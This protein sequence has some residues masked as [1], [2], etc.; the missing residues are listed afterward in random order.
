MTDF[1]ELV[2]AR[3]QVTIRTEIYTSLADEGVTIQGL[4]PTSL[5]KALPE[6]F[7]Q[8]EADAEQSR[9]DMT[10]AAFPSGAVQLTTRPGWMHLHATDF[11]QI[12]P[13]PALETLGQMRITATSAAASSTI[14][15]GQLVIRYG[16]GASQRLYTN[17][18]G[19][20]PIPGSYV[21]VAMTAQVAG[22]A[23]N[24]GNNATLYLV[25]AYPGL[26]ATNPP[27][28]GTQTWITRRGR[29]AEALVSIKQRCDERWAD[30]SFEV[31]S[32]RFARIIRDAFEASGETNPIVRIY[33][34]DTNPDG[35]GSVWVYMARDGT[36]ATADDVT[37]VDAYVTPR[38]R[39][40]GGP[41]KSYAAST[42]T[43][44]LDGT[45]KGPSN[46]ATAL[47]QAS[48]AL[49]ALAPTYAIGGDKVYREQVESALFTGVTGAKNVILTIDE[50][51]DIPAGSIVEF[52]IGTITVTP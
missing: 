26:S 32:Q 29:D 46:S 35:P 51:T 37:L 4:Q 2:I 36:T 23:G 10:Y 42:L 39:T 15:T 18:E 12:T 25:T 3:S 1:S 41:F 48:A 8:I 6:I 38:W 13:D 27:V 34:D 19:F 24:I 40:G 30:L 11:F 45:I 5:L 43:I 50:E 28:T 49:S 17:T 9:V 21:D 31:S 14:Q 44:T 33:V 22:A 20:T 16:S 7:A 47:T 52:A